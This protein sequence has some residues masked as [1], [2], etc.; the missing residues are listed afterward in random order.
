LKPRPYRPLGKAMLD[1]MAGKAEAAIISHTDDEEEPDVIPVEVFFR[2]DHEME[3]LELTALELCHGRVL[4]A[5]AGAGGHALA[6]QEKG[7]IVTAIDVLDEAVK[8]MKARGVKDAQVADVFTYKGGPFDSVL[9]MMNGIGIAGDI[10]GMRSLLR[11]ARELVTDEGVLV[12]D[13][14]DLRADWDWEEGRA[15][16]V[17]DDCRY[18]GITTFRIEYEGKTGKPFEWLFVDPDTLAAFAELEGWYSQVVFME[19][20]G[21]YLARLKKI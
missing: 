19:E 4:D 12:F 8:V 13:S 7:A 5:G 20:D 9:M 2:E 1:Y 14:L 15:W 21:H 18:P 17:A 6:L 3:A 11:K 16:T 10:E